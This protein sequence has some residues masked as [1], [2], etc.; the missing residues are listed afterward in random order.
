MHHSTLF[1][2]LAA[3][4]AL[5]CGLPLFPALPA[6]TPAARVVIGKSPLAPL[7][8]RPGS[9]P[10]ARLDSAFQHNEP[11]QATLAG[12]A[13][14]QGITVDAAGHLFI[15][16]TSNHRVLAWASAAAAATGQAADFVIGQ[17]NG[18]VVRAN[19]GYVYQ[20]P[21]TDA[22]LRLPIALA[23]DSTGA[24]WVEDSGNHRILRYDAPFAQNPSRVR[25]SLV[26]GHDD[27]FHCGFNHEGATSAIGLSSPAGM[28]IQEP[29]AGG[30]FL[31][32][33]DTGNNRVLQFDLTKSDPVQLAT[34]IRVWGQVDFA[35]PL[36]YAGGAV[37]EGNFYQPAGL[38]VLPDGTMAVADYG[39]SRILV[40]PPAAGQTYPGA[41]AKI[42]VGQT[43]NNATQPNQGGY[44]ASATTLYTPRDVSL[45][46]AAASFELI[47]V[48][49]G[50]NRVLVYAG[51]NATGAAL[52]FAPA[53]TKVAGQ[54]DFVAVRANNPVPGPA[55][56]NAP[57]AIWSTGSTGQSW[58]ADGLNHRALHFGAL[59]A[60]STAADRALGQGSFNRITANGPGANLGLYRPSGAAFDERGAAHHL[61]IADSGNHRVLGWNEFR[62]FQPTRPPDV[63]IG[64]PDL[65]SV[66]ANRGG[67]V[68]ANSLYDPGALAV[69][70][71]GALWVADRGNN[72]MLRFPDPFS[73]AFTGA[74]DL[75][76]GQ[77]GFTTGT[78]NLDRGLTDP[79]AACYRP[80]DPNFA[81]LK[82]P[83]DECALWNPG[84]VAF[85]GTSVW[86]ADQLNHRLL[87]YDTL[88]NGAPAAR[89]LGRTETFTVANSNPTRSGLSFYDNALL[90][91]AQNTVSYPAQ[92]AVCAATPCL[93][94]GLPATP[95]VTRAVW[96]ADSGNNRALAFDISSPSTTV[97]PAGIRVLGAI[98]Y[99]N[100]SGGVSAVL[101]NY[102]SGLALGASGD[103]WVS[104]TGNN[105]TLGFN[106][107]ATD[108][109]AAVDLL[110]Q[111]SFSFGDPNPRGVDRDT[112]FGPR[113]V[114]FAADGTVAV[115]DADNNRVLLHHP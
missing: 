68:A 102:P 70:A 72:R 32:V 5:A 17:G 103:V 89:V 107:P 41:P 96:V 111:R 79:N 99:A 49:N 40:F 101:M 76:L 78:A 61:Y 51:L 8:D 100:R 22:T 104:D 46:G 53:A 58:L 21:C 54:G 60:A 73:G 1:P 75:V 15:A 85:A 94:A 67:G 27:F 52:A 64:Q 9:H 39:S 12:L 87:R 4:G 74:A 113:A 36:P 23:A 13:Q 115:A 105:R 81:G 62:A 97:P 42:V 91:T 57:T 48:D 35:T 108:A 24:L 37:N 26:I 20:A 18:G 66:A 10:N 33:S 69:D 50:N 19:A 55:T 109:A 82:K 98:D 110:G 25:P 65:V 45:A 71:N 83:T 3:A 114:A 38:R 43:A 47:A 31:Y 92:I 95:V 44:V 14:P 80:P 16:D 77:P 106:N 34:A 63:V 86:V 28:A 30:R 93:P 6:G 90:L 29:V 88:V 2:R 7:A 59:L 112:A 56:V 84:G 11:N